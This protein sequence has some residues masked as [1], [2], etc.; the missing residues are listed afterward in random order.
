MLYNYVS[1]K[2]TKK[3]EVRLACN[4]RLAV[5]DR[6]TRKLVSSKNLVNI[7]SNYTIHPGTQVLAVRCRNYQSKPWI[8]GSVSNG[9]VTDNRWK[10]FSLPKQKV[11][12]G[13]R[14]A[15]DDF[16]DSHWSQ[17]VT[18]FSNRGNSPW[19]KV[20]DISDEAFWIS[21]ANEKHSRLFCRSMLSDLPQKQSEYSPRGSCLLLVFFSAEAVL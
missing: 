20:P 16:D 11:Q 7:S 18:I 4:G 2:L 17:A 8:I 13:N 12:N 5:Y 14:W 19:G 6:I 15:K 1:A 3:L 9:L 21:T 10:C